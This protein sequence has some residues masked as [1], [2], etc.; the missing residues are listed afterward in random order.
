MKYVPWLAPPLALLL[1]ACGGGA[2]PASTA[3]AKPSEAAKPAASAA[4]AS[5]AAASKPAAA[6]ASANPAASASA[7]PAGSASAAAKP[8]ASG[9]TKVSYAY[10]SVNPLH[11]VAAVAGEKPD[12]FGKYGIQFDGVTTTNSPNAVNA[13]VGGSVNFAATTPDSMWPAQ[14][15]A[16]DVKQVAAVTDG[17]PYVLIAQPDIKRAADLKGKTF[18]ASAVRGGADTTSIM[19]MMLENGVKPNEYT[20]VQAGSVSDRT[21][22]MKAKSIQGLAQLEPQASLLRNEGFPEIDNANNYGSLKNVQSITLSAKKSWY[23]GNPTLAAN[24]IKGWMDTTKWIYD[25]ANKAELLAITKKTMSVGDKE[26]ENAY[27]LHIPNKMVSPDLHIDEKKA[28]QFIDNLKK[29]GAAD[30]L[31]SDPAKYIDNSLVDRALKS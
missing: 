25:P 4:P 24:F 1:A 29:T 16:P 26:A 3:P 13:L 21:V 22:A 9:L 7:K 12:L 31:P 19:V 18:C 8:A 30:N 2:A 15:K 11:Y 28:L 17:T 20:I 27:N 14:D 10:A 5:A 6:S 23:E